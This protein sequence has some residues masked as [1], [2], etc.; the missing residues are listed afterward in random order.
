[1][2]CRHQNK[3]ADTNPTRAGEKKH[4][5]VEGIKYVRG[6]LRMLNFMGF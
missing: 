3:Y 2:F 4:H 6:D 1:M 5:T